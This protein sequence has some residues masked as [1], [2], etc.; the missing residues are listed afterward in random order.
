MKESN[1]EM[2]SRQE[3]DEVI[4]DIQQAAERIRSM[5]QRGL[6]SEEDTRTRT[7]DILEN[8]LFR[9]L[10][11]KRL[12]VH[13]RA[14]DWADFRNAVCAW[15]EDHEEQH[16][17]VCPWLC[18]E[19]RGRVKGDF[20]TVYRGEEA[21]VSD[22]VN[23]LR[24]LEACHVPIE[25]FRPVPEGIIRPDD[26]PAHFPGEYVIGWNIWEADDDLAQ[27]KWKAGETIT[28]TDH[29]GLKTVMQI[30][31][32]FTETDK[33]HSCDADYIGTGTIEGYTS[34]RPR[35][36]KVFVEDGKIDSLT[37]FRGND[38]NIDFPL[39]KAYTEDRAEIY[40]IYEK[41]IRDLTGE[42]AG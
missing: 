26:H 10:G 25:F 41:I 4:A 21:A 34:P 38:D 31:R 36:I 29:Y 2:L 8:S 6:L 14:R 11:E 42:S 32:V 28:L 30:D 16:L 20:T 27:G 40:R 18:I 35:E 24:L 7:V 5:I 13:I 9:F 12:A 23:V 1:E 37:F 33:K 22:K 39:W 15:R 3:T 17:R 19:L